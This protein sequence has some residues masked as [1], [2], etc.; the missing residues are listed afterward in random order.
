MNKSFILEAS[1]ISRY[2]GSVYAVTQYI[3][4]YDNPA[5]L[6]M[7]QISKAVW[8]PFMSGML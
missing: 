1:A 4:G 7:R 8:G 6:Q 2:S 5:S 3:V